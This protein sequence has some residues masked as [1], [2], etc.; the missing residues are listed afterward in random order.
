MPIKCDVS[1][2]FSVWLL[3]VN[4][5]FV[6]RLYVLL[7]YSMNNSIFNIINVLSVCWFN[8]TYHC[9]YFIVKW[10][11]NPIWN[12]KLNE[13][14]STHLKGLLCG[15]Y[16]FLSSGLSKNLSCFNRYWSPLRCVTVT[17]GNPICLVH[18]SIIWPTLKRPFTACIK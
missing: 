7:K 12:K 4:I 11:N 2:T 6:G 9:V 17:T 3:K 10:H 16:F 18:V 8:P 14:L 13:C 15:L 1:V 5:S